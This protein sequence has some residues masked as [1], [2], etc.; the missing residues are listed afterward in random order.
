[1]IDAARKT[2]FAPVNDEW[3]FEMTPVDFLVNVM[4]RFAKDPQ[5]FGH[6]YNAVNPNPLP[7][8]KVFDLM[9]EKNLVSERVSV[10]E[11][12]T[13]L[14]EKARNEGDSVLGVLAQS[15]D[16]VEM[17]LNDKSI[18]DCS[19]FEAALSKRRLRRPATDRSYFEKVL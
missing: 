12:K 3:A 5:H 17:Y 16:E 7:A 9:D 13:G 8:S 10:E 4:V 15:L 11:W 1:M 19:Q 6:V 14:T 18:Y 2:G